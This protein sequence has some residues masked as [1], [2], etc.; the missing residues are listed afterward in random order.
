VQHF[1]S[2]TRLSF[3]VLITRPIIHPHTVSQI[4][5]ELDNSMNDAYAYVY[6]SRDSRLID[7]C[8]LVDLIMKP[9]WPETF[10]SRPE[11][12]IKQLQGNKQRSTIKSSFNASSSIAVAALSWKRWK[13]IHSS[14]F[15]LHAHVL[16]QYAT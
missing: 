16:R 12:C 8:G 15:T 3:S 14:V 10:A 1:R 4:S 7:M 9:A 11:W 13:S 2:F 6:T 5:A